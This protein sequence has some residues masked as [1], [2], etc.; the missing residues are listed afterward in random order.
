MKK[1]FCAALIF[2]LIMSL[3]GCFKTDVDD[4]S[5]DNNNTVNS[6][7]D[8]TVLEN[9]TSD[10]SNI[11]QSQN[12]AKP[13]GN[14]SQT[15]SSPSGTV[16]EK[17]IT[18]TVKDEETIS[19]PE[20][21][22]PTVP[23]T[24]HTPLSRE[25]YYQ[26]SHSSA[27]EKQ[28][29]N[30]ICTAIETTQNVIN[31]KKYFLSPEKVKAIYEKVTADNPQYFWVT[32]FMTYS[33]EA[34]NSE[35]RLISLYLF[36]TDGET[37]DTIDDNS[38][39]FTKMADRDKISQQITQ[40][41][42]KAEE[43]IKTVPTN[44]SAVEKEKL[45]HDFVLKNITYDNDAV[46][47]SPN[48]ENYLRAWDAYGALCKNKAVCEGYAR[49]FQYLCYQVGIN[50]TY[51]QGTSQGVGHAWNII[52]LDNDWYHIDTTWDDGSTDGN[53]IYS[54]FNLTEAQIK[55]DHT[56]TSDNIYVP[57][58]EGSKYSLKNTF[59][60]SIDSITAAP[61]NYQNA[62]DYMV[63][64]GDTRIT[65]LLNGNNLSG[66]YFTQHFLGDNST[67]GK[68]IKSKGYNLKFSNSY[69]IS[70]DG[71]YLYLKKA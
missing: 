25:Y 10:S 60:M 6:G 19:S 34:I 39:E 61:S 4:V 18:P 37:T 27:T 1:L 7:N 54:W 36:Y 28:V 8:N 5:S 49:L 44:V 68:Y 40:F 62:I 47:S 31:L 70:N 55:A 2:A 29:Y 32:K 71:K 21:E 41:N 63:K 13:Q 59:A 46:S 14:A 69:S 57:K 35:E 9:S 12:P 15:S 26:Y 38:G 17:P 3:C 56:I 42:A 65:V 67:V 11:S 48:R 24:P 22:K 53:A 52:K 64:F 45:I 33:Y 16:V 50:T 51:V 66:S 20:I 23:D 58:A 43:F 30:D